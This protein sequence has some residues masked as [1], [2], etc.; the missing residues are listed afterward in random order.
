[1]TRRVWHKRVKRALLVHCAVLCAYSSRGRCLRLY[2][3][4][5]DETWSRLTITH[6]LF[7]LSPCPCCGR[8]AP[9]GGEGREEGGTEDKR[10]GKSLGRFR[11]IYRGGSKEKK[12]K[13]AVFLVHAHAQRAHG[14][15]NRLVTPCERASEQKRFCAGLDWAGLGYSLFSSHILSYPTL[16]YP[17]LSSIDCPKS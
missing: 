7:F 2:E 4:R 1:M 16:S 11:P 10:H 6:T 8:K 3:T 13:R 5:R 15:G 9:E 12:K 17:I 14:A